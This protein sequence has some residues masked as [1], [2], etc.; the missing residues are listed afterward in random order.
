MLLVFFFIDIYIY[1]IKIVELA[2]KSMIKSQDKTY[3]TLLRFDHFLRAGKN[4]GHKYAM[5]QRVF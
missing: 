2:E 4:C 1:L 5:V 3:F